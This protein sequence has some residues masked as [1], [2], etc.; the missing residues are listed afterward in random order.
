[1][2]PGHMIPLIDIAVLLCSRGV[3]TSRDHPGNERFALLAIH[4]PNSSFPPLSPSKW[5]SFPSFRFRCLSSPTAAR[6]FPAYRNPYPHLFDASPSLCPS[7]HNLLLR[8]SADFLISDAMFTWTADLARNFVAIP[9]IVFNGPGA[10]PLRHPLALLWTL[11][12]E[13]SSKCLLNL[14]LS[15]ERIHQ[16]NES[17]V[18][19]IWAHLRFTNSRKFLYSI[20]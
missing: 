14:L 9:S 13:I 17:P 20:F 18:P 2:S 19:L 7:L 3:F 11:I 15:K 16:K 10:F 12:S 5:S 6:T 8:R 1:M 4:R